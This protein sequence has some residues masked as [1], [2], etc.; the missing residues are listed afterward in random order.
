MY[1]IVSLKAILFQAL[2]HSQV[3]SFLQTPKHFVQSPKYFA[4]RARGSCGVDPSPV[5]LRIVTLS[6]SPMGDWLYGVRKRL[7][8]VRSSMFSAFAMLCFTALTV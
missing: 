8:P 4:T 7:A 5:R 6:A 2:Q 3:H 1:D